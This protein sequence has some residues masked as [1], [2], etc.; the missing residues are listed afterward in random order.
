MQKVYKEIYFLPMKTEVWLLN[1]CTL[2]YLW[3]MKKCLLYYYTIILYYY[4]SQYSK[5]QEY[6]NF[7]VIVM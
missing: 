5:L 3:E 2:Q 6:L 4:T 7:L 1:F